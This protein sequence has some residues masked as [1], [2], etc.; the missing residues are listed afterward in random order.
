MPAS[1]A[2][3]Q[4]TGERWFERDA[5]VLLAAREKS[6]LVFRNWLPPPELTHP[7]F[8]YYRNASPVLRRMLAA[9]AAGMPHLEAVRLESDIAADEVSRFWQEFLPEL[10]RT[11]GDFAGADGHAQALRE[12]FGVET[13]LR[14]ERIA[15]RYVHM[16]RTRLAPHVYGGV[17]PTLEKRWC[18]NF[19]VLVQDLLLDGQAAFEDYMREPA[20]AVERAAR[21][22]PDTL[23]HFI[24]VMRNETLRFHTR[25]LRIVTR[26]TTVMEDDIP[27]LV[28]YREQLMSRLPLG[29]IWLPELTRSETG[30]WNCLNFRDEA[31]GSTYQLRAS[32]AL[33]SPEGE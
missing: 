15:E 6:E 8:I 22:T 28:E 29:E 26:T 10:A 33:A 9:L 12:R 30:V 16:L 23:L 14:Q 25:T 18:F 2:H 5:G 4:A 13:M 24:A 3:T 11:R 21:C 19:H 32:A 31:G 27:G 7:D 20:R 17:A 1:V